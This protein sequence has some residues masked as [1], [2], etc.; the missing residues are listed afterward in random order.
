MIGVLIMTYTK[1]VWFNLIAAMLQSLSAMKQ[2]IGTPR[3]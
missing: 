3:V 2:F 1:L